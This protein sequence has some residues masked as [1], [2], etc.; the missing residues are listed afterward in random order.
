V[1]KRA[2]QLEMK[3]NA[4]P[5][6]IA[7]C[8]TEYASM[9][10]DAAR[11]SQRIAALFGRYEKLGVDQRAIKHSYAAAQKDPTEAAAQHRRNSEYLALLEII[12]FGSEGQGTFIAGLAV[13]KPGAKASEGIRA[14]RAHADGYNSGLAGGKIEAC[15]FATG[16][17]E[18]VSWRD[19]WSD[20]H[21]DRV[22]RNPDADKVTQS[23]PRKRGR[24]RKDGAPPPAAKDEIGA[25]AGHA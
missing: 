10:A 23:E 3:T 13:A 2:K 9:R 14:A 20:G 6:E 7:A 15:K 22:A 12:D 11:V 24:P 25:A 21:A 4:D 5:N 8:F 19:G 18:F 16:S 17:E 1:A